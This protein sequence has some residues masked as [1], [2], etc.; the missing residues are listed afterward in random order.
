MT[1]NSTSSLGR[2]EAE[3]R[4]DSPSVVCG[5]VP[6]LDLNTGR[7]DS[8]A[9]FLFLVGGGAGAP[10]REA[11]YSAGVLVPEKNGL[12]KRSSFF[13]LPGRDVMSF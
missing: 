1:L 7:P 6:S 11:Q 2:N 8:R 4:G 5:M 10:G 13:L 9:R 3:K 12:T